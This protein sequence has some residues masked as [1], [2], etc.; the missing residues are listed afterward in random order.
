MVS[1]NNKYTYWV[2]DRN[3]QRAF[4]LPEHIGKECNHLGITAEEITRRYNEYA[5]LGMR[6]TYADG[7]LKAI[8]NK[9]KAQ[10]KTIQ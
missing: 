2:K 7:A 4:K 9:K 1:P 3:G 5:S 8:F 6:V 10:G